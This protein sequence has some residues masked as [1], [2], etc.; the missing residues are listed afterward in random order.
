MVKVLIH[1][2]AKDLT[3]KVMAVT[4]KCM[5]LKDSFPNFNWEF[6]NYDGTLTFTAAWWSGET[7]ERF[8][9]PV[10]MVEV[11]KKYEYIRHTLEE[12]KWT[13]LLYKEDE[14]G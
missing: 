4:R 12:L 5:E 7:G 8:Q 11:D 14:D 3:D 13:A 6:H 1:T 2:Q 10:H 9:F